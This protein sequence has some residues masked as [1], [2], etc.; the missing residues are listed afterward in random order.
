VRSGD[1]ARAAPAVEIFAVG[2]VDGGLLHWL[3]GALHQ[4][5]RVP[6]AIG[7]EFASRPDW[8]LEQADSWSANALLDSLVEAFLVSGLDP[9]ARIYLAVSVL[10]MA[11]PGRTVVFGVATV[12]G[13]CAVVCTEALHAEDIELFRQR[14]L[15]EA[16]HEIGHVR[17]L[18]HCHDRACV[19]FASADLAA[20][21]EKSVHFCASCAKMIIPDLPKV[22]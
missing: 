4:Q 17:G 7:R 8:K 22:P 18:G 12:G 11:E 20:T 15:K 5:L 10:P 1:P 6:V 16:V 2:L 3:A 9:E 21:D 13:C 14:V 19:M